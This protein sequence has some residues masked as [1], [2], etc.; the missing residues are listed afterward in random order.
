[1][2]FPTGKLHIMLVQQVPLTIVVAWIKD[3]HMD[4]NFKLLETGTL[5]SAILITTFTLQVILWSSSGG[6]NLGSVIR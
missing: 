3:I 6:C 4:L 2:Q 1:M 5:V